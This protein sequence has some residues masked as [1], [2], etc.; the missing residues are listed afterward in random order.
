MTRACASRDTRYGRAMRTRARLVAVSAVSILLWSCTS[1]PL[2]TFGPSPAA[3]PT[4]GAPSATAPG[5]TVNETQVP[6]LTVTDPR[7]SVTPDIDLR[8]G[9]VVRVAVTGFSV[10]GKVWLSE[11]SSAAVATDEGCGDQL[12]AQTFLVTRNDRTGTSSFVVHSTASSHE[13]AGPFTRCED[14]CVLVATLGGGFPF[15][16]ARLSFSR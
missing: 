8:E 5:P 6:A 11:C 10:G 15:V 13:L 1:A 7:V 9:E 16:T 12:A 4:A 14:A 3:A 2:P